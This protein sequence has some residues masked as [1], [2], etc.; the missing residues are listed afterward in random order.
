[1]TLEV[2]EYSAGGCD[3]TRTRPTDHWCDVFSPTMACE[4]VTLQPDLAKLIGASRRRT[5]YAVRPVHP[6]PRA[7][8]RGIVNIGQILTPPISGGRIQVCCRR[9]CRG[10]GAS[11]RE[12]GRAIRID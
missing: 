11:K 10:P 12:E 6:H 3:F 2:L 5:R 9:R 7:I 4:S 8:R 1:V